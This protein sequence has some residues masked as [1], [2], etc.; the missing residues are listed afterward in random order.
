MTS[1]FTNPKAFLALFLIV[2]LGFG[3]VWL[4]FNLPD[5]VID[6]LFKS[7]M[8]KRQDRNLFAEDGLY[9]ITTGTGAPLPDVNRAG[10]QA[11]VVA[12][13]EILIFDAGPGSTHRIEMIGLDTNAITALFLTHYHSDHIGDIGELMLKHWATAGA[14]EPLPIYGPPGLEE[15]LAGFEAAYRLDQTYRIA[16]HGTDI[17][18]PSGFGG[19][20][21][22]FDLGT[23]LMA[24]E[25]VYQ[26]GE[27]EVIAFNVDHQPVFPAVGYRV[28]YKG[29]SVVITGD[30]IYTESLTQHAMGADV[31]V[32]EV[33]NHKFADMLVDAGQESETNVSAVAEDIQTY[34]ITPEE[35]GI[36][37][38]NAEIPTLVVTHILPPVPSPLLVNPFLRDLRRVYTGSI[39]LAS[40]GTMVKLPVGSQKVT[41]IE[42]LKKR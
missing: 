7:V 17:M 20:A 10:P 18:P 38:R 41:I 9:V 16:H 27:V 42:L 37:A 8:N 39:T 35:V 1:I 19:E 6:F 21:H 34:H 29:R 32:S 40:D 30:T 31:L 24:S 26:S 23:D 15:V 28:N 13:D 12:G 2:V 33:L 36:V 4:L 22:L 25:V 3:L 11:V 14:T 5:S